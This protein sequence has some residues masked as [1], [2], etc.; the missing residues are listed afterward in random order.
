MKQTTGADGEPTKTLLCPGKGWGKAGE[1]FLSL[2]NC[3]VFR[4]TDSQKTVA[5]W[6]LVTPHPHVVIAQG[7]LPGLPQSINRAEITALLS[8]ALWATPADALVYAYS[9]SQY[10]CNWFSF[11]RDHGFIPKHVENQD[12]WQEVQTVLIALPAERFQ[13]R[14]VSSHMD[15]G[16]L[17]GPYDEWLAKGND[18][19]DIT[20]KLAVR[21]VTASFRSIYES[22][23]EHL[24]DSRRRVRNQLHFLMAVAHRDLESPAVPDLRD[25]EDDS[26]GSF[27]FENDASLAAQLT[28][29]EDLV[30]PFVGPFSSDVVRNFSVWLAGIDIMAAHKHFVTHI[31]LLAILFLTKYHLPVPLLEQGRKVFKER[32]QVVA[33][34]LHR[35]T[36]AG[37]LQVLSLLLH[38][39]LISFRSNL[40]RESCLS[41]HLVCSS[42]LEL[43]WLFRMTLFVLLVLCFRSGPKIDL[44]DGRPI[45]LGLSGEPSEQWSAAQHGPL[46]SGW[47]IRLRENKIKSSA[48]TPNSR[49]MCEAP[50]AYFGQENVKMQTGMVNR[51]RVMQ[52]MHFPQAWCT[53]QLNTHAL[54]YLNRSHLG[55]FYW[56]QNFISLSFLSVSSMSKL[57]LQ[58]M[59]IK[60]KDSRLYL[61]AICINALLVWSIS[62]TSVTSHVTGAKQASRWTLS[63]PGIRR[64][65][66]GGNA[67]VQAWSSSKLDAQ[68]TGSNMDSSYSTP[69]IKAYTKTINKL[70]RK[71]CE[72]HGKV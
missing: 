59:N 32:S 36:V 70:N 19:A 27:I 22:F 42:L 58:I 3:K 16:Q 10:T 66:C 56:L 67:S 45:F 26:V 17:D 33:G 60:F 49:S 50:A 47:S 69:N 43:F 57:T 14:K 53:A 54:W 7:V 6:A 15:W 63:M 64:F 44:F 61:L 2:V 18:F 8:A 35:Y 55:C 71:S 23:V 21:N 52:F 41:P 13:W 51:R 38:S 39:I 4:R 65:F 40:L 28:V 11:I 5:A 48:G 62:K 20:A 29:V 9:D 12:L 25:P 72:R 68:T 37:A 24:E 31:E 34:D 1:V 46:M 30:V